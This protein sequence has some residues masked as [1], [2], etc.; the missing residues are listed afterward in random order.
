VGGEADV[1]VG[2]DWMTAIL[3]P[4]SSPSDS[5]ENRVLNAEQKRGSSVRH[6]HGRVGS[7]R[8]LL[9]TEPS[10][11]SSHGGKTLWTT[12]PPIRPSRWSQ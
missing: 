1:E 6:G 11:T 7:I 4:T 2:L 8:Y 9:P 10:Y 5:K 3:Y 12:A